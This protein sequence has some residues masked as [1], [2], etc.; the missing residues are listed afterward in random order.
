MFDLG[1]PAVG[2]LFAADALEEVFEGIN[3]PFVRGEPDALVG[4]H[5]G[6]PVGHGCDQVAQEGRGGHFPGLPVQVH[7]GEL[8][9]AVDGDEQVKFA[10][11][12]LNPSDIDVKVA[13]GV[14][15]EFF[16]AGL[17]PST[18][19]RREMSWRCKQRCSDDRVR[20][21]IDGCSA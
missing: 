19:G 11:G 4:E 5:D 14:G 9:G 1:E 13:E 17:S 2:P 3:M 20:C 12:R 6:E 21:G 18:S 8:G 10:F 7:E 15:L 16:F